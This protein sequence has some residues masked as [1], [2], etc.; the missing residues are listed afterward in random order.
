MRQGT[1]GKTIVTAIMAV[2]SILF[3]SPLIWM[4]S[5]ASKFEKDVMAFPIRW[6]PREWNFIE[7]FKTVWMGDVPFNL[8]Y[9]NSLKLAVISTLLT[10]LFSSMAGFSFAKLNF[11]FKNGAFI[12]LLSFFL[13]PNE[14]TLVPRFIMIRWLHLYDT[15]ASLILMGAFTI[16]LTFLMRQFMMGIHQEYI[17]AGKMDGAGIFRIYWQIVLPMAKPII[18]TVGILKFLWTWNDYQGPLIFLM[19]PKLFTITLGMQSFNDIYST[20]YAVVMMAAVSA[21]IPLLILFILLQ[22]QVIDGIAGGGVKG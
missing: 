12:L 4:V 7:N 21:I 15:H 22:R 20:S 13:I 11:P 9:F 14:A 18:A 16:P 1:T 2:F 19:D 8:H 10:L 17:E 5:A 3:I 6:I